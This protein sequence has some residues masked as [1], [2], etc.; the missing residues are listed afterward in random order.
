MTPPR[1]CRPAGTVLVLVVVCAAWAWR[2]CMLL[3]TSVVLAHRLF[4][5]RMDCGALWRALAAAV[6]A[7]VAGGLATRHRHG[8]G[9]PARGQRN[10]L[11]TPHSAS[12]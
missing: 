4:L 10:A 12:G 3:A 1:L 9:L 2:D 11:S 7:M 6:N 8:I 5:L